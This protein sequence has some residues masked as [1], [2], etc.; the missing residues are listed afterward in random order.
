MRTCGNK[1]SD[2]VSATK[3]FLDGTVGTIFVLVEDGSMSVRECATFD[4]LSRKTYVISL[5]NK[6]RECQGF[7]S[8]P[9]NAL[10]LFDRLLS[11]LED[12]YDL[13]MKSSTLCWQGCN[14]VP[15]FGQLLHFYAG[16]VEPITI[17][18]FI[19]LNRRPVIRSPIFLVEFE[20]FTFYVRILHFG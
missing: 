8:S 10:F 17:F 13:R 20:G 16:I 1:L 11:C 7:S 5:S 3:S 12:L 4:V 6:G 2:R 18:V 19:L 14:L 15:Y 9:I